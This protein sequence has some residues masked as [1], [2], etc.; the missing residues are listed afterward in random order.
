MPYILKKTDGTTL[1]TVDDA[2]LDLTTDLSF[3]GRNYSG[4]GQ[5][6]NENFLKILENFANSTP[7]SSPIRGQLWYDTTNKLL[8]VSNDGK[9]FKGIANIFI[10][11]TVPFQG[12]NRGDLWWD[13]DNLQLKT[14]DGSQFQVI[15]PLSPAAT[16]AYWVPGDEIGDEASVIPV[17]KA[18]I[19][20][21]QESSEIIAVISS[22]E[23]V[24]VVGSSLRA[25]YPI[26]KRGI[27]LKGASAITGRSGNA[28]TGTV[29]WGTVAEALSAVT[30][31]FATTAL[32]LARGGAE[33]LR[34][35]T[36]TVY[37]S[38]STS[39]IA[40]TI[41]ERDVGGNLWANNFYG[42]ASSAR[43]ADLAERYA[44]DSIYDV[45][46]VL[47]IGG[48][49]E[50]TV[51]NTHAAT[52][53]VGIVSKNPAYMM[54]S[55]AGSDDTH[56]FIALKGR[57]PCKVAGPVKRGDL[58]VTSIYEGYATTA[59]PT[60]HPCAVIGKALEDNNKSLGLIEILVI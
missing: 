22:S 20:G 45:G 56:P 52:S 44:A 21:S 38:A 54:N 35:S 17:L 15:G 32:D 16:K 19:A 41:A 27:T 9:T 33:K 43:F 11:P 40:H 58:L 57:V 8:K 48:E 59:Q 26:I 6:V 49:K 29:L 46:T 12:L 55:D 37:I 4:Y 10:Q 42:I 3:V 7:P 36:S 60:D 24:P 53:V 31:T 18:S 39:S 28:T 2:S 1:T 51:T 47:V 14:F 25:T 34:S 5:V 23:F 13:S 50:V 30:A